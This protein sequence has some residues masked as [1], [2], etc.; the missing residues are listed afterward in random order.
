MSVHDKFVAVAWV[1]AAVYGLLVAGFG[2]WWVR[3]IFRH[4]KQDQA[5][6]LLVGKAGAK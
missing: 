4:R 1:S 2:A 5:E 6:A 3:D